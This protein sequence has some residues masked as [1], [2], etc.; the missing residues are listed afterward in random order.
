MK[1][2]R[3][4]EIRGLSL[5]DIQMK[6]LVGGTQAA[7]T[8]ACGTKCSVKSTYV[9]ATNAMKECVCGGKTDDGGFKV[10][11]CTE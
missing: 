3:I 1:R 9:C 11:K 4:N 10:D 8:K 6:N 2:K 7:A 5:S